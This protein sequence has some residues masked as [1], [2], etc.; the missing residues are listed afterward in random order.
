MKL[1]YVGYFCPARTSTCSA[2]SVSEAAMQ[3][4][5]SR[6]S[7]QPSGSWRNSEYVSS[8]RDSSSGS[9]CPIGRGHLDAPD[10][11]VL[12][13]LPSRRPRRSPSWRIQ[14]EGLLYLREPL[15]DHQAPLLRY[16]LLSAAA[17]DQT[18]AER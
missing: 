17:E 6:L 5:S 3:T 8:E 11:R 10:M 15:R 1:F 13:P 16:S 7:E 18:G 2:I 12:R 9:R 14:T 4:Y